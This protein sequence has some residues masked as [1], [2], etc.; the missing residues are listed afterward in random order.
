MLHQL[1]TCIAYSDLQ[2]MQINRKNSNHIRLLLNFI[3]AYTA[4]FYVKMYLSICMVWGVVGQCESPSFA[5]VWC[6]GWVKGPRSLF[7][8]SKITEAWGNSLHDE[9]HRQDNEKEVLKPLFPLL[10][11]SSQ[12]QL[13]DNFHSRSEWRGPCTAQWTRKDTVSFNSKFLRL[14]VT[15]KHWL[16]SGNW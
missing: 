10:P 3:E 4:L 1:Y 9:N 7:R 12:V 2:D 6:G 5:N 14:Y 15:F 13:D 11:V 16:S 8:D